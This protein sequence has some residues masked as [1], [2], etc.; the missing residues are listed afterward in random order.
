M[1][2]GYKHAVEAV[3][4]IVTGEVDAAMNKYNKKVKAKE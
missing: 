1:E 2:E 4:M 3:S